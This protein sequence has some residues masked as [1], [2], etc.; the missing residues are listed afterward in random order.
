M[1]V[2]TLAL[3]LLASIAAGNAYGAAAPRPAPAPVV[4]PPE[5]WWHLRDSN[6]ISG[7]ETRRAF[8]GSANVINLPFP[9]QGAQHAQLQ[10]RSHP[11]FGRDAQLIIDKGQFQCSMRC[12]VTV[13]F[14]DATPRT[15]SAVG[16]DDHSTT[17]L[18]ILP[19][20]TFYA[21]VKKAKRVRIEAPFYAA[22]R[23]V[24]DFSMATFD[25]AKFEG[26]SVTQ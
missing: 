16:P 7:K 23:R 8:T 25:P 13:R 15:F 2:R 19:F 4:V 10:L 5:Q 18:F 12:A 17:T 26:R 11:R 1:I 9:Y 3:A 20:K 6:D 24:F 14:D 22:G 21:A